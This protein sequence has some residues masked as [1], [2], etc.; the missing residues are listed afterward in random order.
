MSKL[1]KVSLLAMVIA[2][3]TAANAGVRYVAA[4]DSKESLIC[5]SAA[6][7]HHMAFAN[8]LERV[9]FTYKLVANKLDCNGQDIASFSAAAGN[10]KT[11]S[12]LARHS[13][14]KG[15]VQ[16]KEVAAA[17]SDLRRPGAAQGDIVILVKGE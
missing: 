14:S 11:A 12:I 1:M 7:D 9:G 4:D 6:V 13:W 10:L 15:S 8:K 3:A 2:G 5:V 16:I 17:N